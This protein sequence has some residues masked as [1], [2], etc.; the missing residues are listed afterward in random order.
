[1][2][3]S[4]AHRKVLSIIREKCRQVGFILDRFRQESDG[5]DGTTY[6]AGD[7]R[8]PAKYVIVNFWIGP[9]DDH[10]TELYRYNCRRYGISWNIY[11]SVCGTIARELDC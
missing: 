6:S 11:Y 5:D 1:M 7:I 10:K 8:Q 2:R 9:R 3:S 4:S